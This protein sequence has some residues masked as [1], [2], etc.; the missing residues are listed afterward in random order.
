[1]SGAW[2]ILKKD[3]VSYHR[4]W[5]GVLV[6]FAFLLLSGIF[7]TIF[8][9][10]YSQLSFEAARQ[11][12]RGVEDLSITAFIMGAFLLNVGVLFLF[13]A[14][15]LS[16]RSLAEEK[17]VGTLEFLYTYPLS[18]FEI[19]LG[20]YLSLVSQSVLLFLPTLAYAAVIHWLGAKVDWGIIGGGTAGCFLLGASFLAM[21]LFFSSLTE[22][23]MLAGGLTFAFLLGLW[24]LEWL[25]GFLPS[26]LS[27]RLADL[28]PFMHFRD[29]SLGIVD[30]TDVSYFLCLISFFFF[31]TLR[32]VESRNWKG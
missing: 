8:V 9:L 32:D 6:L 22:N 28:S 14:P 19:V 4:S 21:G 18:D 16:M 17:R 7:F 27:T 13:F 30:L 5:V 3:F 20:K 31:L 25:T 11:A 24:M 23:Q 1:M 12:Y 26:F 2:A 29:F 10:S 15:L